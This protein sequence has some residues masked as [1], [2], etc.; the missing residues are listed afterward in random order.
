MLVSSSQERGKNGGAD[1]VTRIHSDTVCA[2]FGGFRSIVCRQ[3]EQCVYCISGIRKGTPYVAFVSKK[4]LLP[5]A[6]SG[7]VYKQVLKV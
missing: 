2:L 3:R 4:L 5:K 6:S 7:D 1:F